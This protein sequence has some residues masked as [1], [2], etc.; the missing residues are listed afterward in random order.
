[1]KFYF[2]Y[3]ALKRA[4]P[5]Q[6]NWKEWLKINQF[7][8]SILALLWQRVF[9]SWVMP[10]SFKM[11]KEHTWQVTIWG[12]MNQPVLLD[13]SGKPCKVNEIVGKPT[14]PNLNGKFLYFFQTHLRM[15]ATIHIFWSVFY[16]VITLLSLPICHQKIY[17]KK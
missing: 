17:V 2:S 14:T 13:G 10:I 8:H 15:E 5:K 7:N 16:S 9:L 12:F 4:H 11:G 6:I 3:L 1:M